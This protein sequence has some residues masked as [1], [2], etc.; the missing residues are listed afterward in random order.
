MYLSTSAWI[1]VSYN[2]AWK[3]I[4]TY[5]ICKED[6]KEITN[7]KYV[8]LYKCLNH[9]FIW[10]CLE[11]YKI[12]GKCI[13]NKHTLTWCWLVS[14]YPGMCTNTT[15][16]QSIK[17]AQ[18]S[19]WVGVGVLSEHKIKVHWRHARSAHTGTTNQGWRRRISAHTQD[20]FVMCGF[21]WASR[22]LSKPIGLRQGGLL[23]SHTHHHLHVG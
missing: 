16:T 5:K 20:L 14:T 13:V 21:N 19:K 7:Q 11:A 10:W 2:G 12:R 8:P 22:H 18:T 15:D 17:T 6:E 3:L 1:I 4:N 9:C 23:S